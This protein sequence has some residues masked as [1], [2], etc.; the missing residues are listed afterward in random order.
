MKSRTHES[1][2]VRRGYNNIVE[3]YEGNK[4]LMTY[5]RKQ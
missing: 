3:E 5:N 4:L 1:Y 2:T